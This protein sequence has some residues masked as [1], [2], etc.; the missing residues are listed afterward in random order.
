M[1]SVNK[2]PTNWLDCQ[3]FQKVLAHHT[4][5]RTLEVDDVQL[6]LQGNAALQY[7]STIYQAIVSYRSRGNAESIKLIVKLISSKVNSVTDESS[8]DTELNVYRDYLAKVDSVF[9][10]SNK[11]HFGP[12]LI[13]AASEPTPYI[14]LEDLTSQQFVHCNKLLG[15]D[16]AKVVLMK[17]AQFHATSYSL[18]NSSKQSDVSNRADNALFKQKAS[19]GMKFMQDNLGIFIEEVSQWQGYEKYAQ[20]LTNILHTFV[21]RGTAIYDPRVHEFNVLIH[22]DFHYNN[23]LFKFDSDNRVQDVLFYDFQLSCWT[24]PAVDLLYFLYFIC[25]RETRNSQRQQLLQMYQQEFTRTLNDIGH[26]G[27]G[28]ALLDINCD[29]LQ[30]GFLEVVIAICF[31]PFLFA[32]YNHVTDVY[33]GKNEDARVYRRKLYSNEE[34]QAIIKPLLPHFLHKGFLD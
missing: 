7:A 30:A 14:I 21:E 15:L 4:A 31:V 28:P 34:Y 20:R 23:M 5:D 32:D 17:L 26:M 19:E 18:N 27:K 13:Y 16:D 12:K 10:E 3:L 2:D 29:L 24:T 11:S 22:G 1:P 6:A 25:D 33:I 8:F 9:G